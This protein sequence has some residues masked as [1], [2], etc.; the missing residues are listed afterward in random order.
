MTELQH[1]V[2]DATFEADHTFLLSTRTN[3]PLTSAEVKK[4]LGKSF[5][6][7]DMATVWKLHDKLSHRDEWTYNQMIAVAAKGGYVKKAFSLYQKMKKVPLQPSLS[8]Y[9]WLLHACV[10]GKE[11]DGNY[12]GRAFYVIEQM[13]SV[14]IPMNLHSYNLLLQICANANDIEVAAEVLRKMAASGIAADISSL[15]S[16]LNCTR[17]D[18]LGP[19]QQVWNELRSKFTPDSRAWNTYLNVLVDS[20]FFDQAISAFNEMI[21]TPVPPEEDPYATPVNPIP[22]A[23]TLSLIMDACSENKNYTEA[24][25]ILVRVLSPEDWRPKIQFDEILFHSMIRVASRLKSNVVFMV[26]KMMI[27]TKAP[28]NKTSRELFIMAYGRT[29][30]MKGALRH[31]EAARMTGELNLR[32][33]TGLLIAC[34]TSEDADRA[35][36]SFDVMQRV[37]IRPD[38]VYLKLLRDIVHFSKRPDLIKRLNEGLLALT[39]P[40]KSNVESAVDRKEKEIESTME[41]DEED[42]HFPSYEDALVQQAQASQRAK[43]SPIQKG[44]SYPTS[45]RIIHGDSSRPEQV[46]GDDFPNEAVSQ[47]RRIHSPVPHV[48]LPTETPSASKST[49]FAS[50][51]MLRKRNEQGDL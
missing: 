41:D 42:Q 16:L 14:K 8:T 2:I 35:L 4:E 1:S 19:I 43:S 24:R 27:E 46:Y 13:E 44:S 37:N 36:L 51:R 31:F 28:I 22:S 10:N 20:K 30:D 47:P 40:K 33:F 25:K 23:H 34:R 29:H 48:I 26:E 17:G 50:E 32:C 38:E 9:H 3:A 7:A 39:P 45:S 18:Q 6:E 15:S 5:R 49:F 12:L 21:S 11:A